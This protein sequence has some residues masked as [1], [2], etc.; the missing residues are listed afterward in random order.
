[1][2]WQLQEEGIWRRRSLT[3]IVVISRMIHARSYPMQPL[4]PRPKAKNTS[5]ICFKR[6][7]G[8]SSHR[9]GRKSSASEP[10]TS[11]ERHIT[12]WLLQIRVF[13]GNRFVWGMVVSPPGSMTRSNGLENG[14]WRRKDSLITA[15]RLSTRDKR[16]LEGIWPF[17]RVLRSVHRRS[18][19]TGWSPSSYKT[20][21]SPADVDPTPA[22]I[23]SG[24]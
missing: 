17:P 3:A 6:S 24:K 7:W 23:T 13:S 10:K 14:G 12:Y 15:W 22:S 21:I 9:S 1:M 16:E 4:L 8:E 18:C 5:S 20:A 2:L 11:F 19:H